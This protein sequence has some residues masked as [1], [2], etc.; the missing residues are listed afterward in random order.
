MAHPNKEIYLS[1]NNIVQSEIDESGNLVFYVM[2]EKSVQQGPTTDLI[3]NVVEQHRQCD[4]I[5]ASS[6]L[7]SD[8]QLIANP[9]AT[10]SMDA[11]GTVYQYQYTVPAPSVENYQILLEDGATNSNMEKVRVERVNSVEQFPSDNLTSTISADMLNDSTTADIILASAG[12]DIGNTSTIQVQTFPSRDCGTMISTPFTPSNVSLHNQLMQDPSNLEDAQLLNNFSAE[13]LESLQSLLDVDVDT[14]I[15]TTTEELMDSAFETRH[16]SISHQG[17][18]NSHQTNLERHVNQRLTNEGASFSESHGD[19]RRS[20][21]VL[22]KTRNQGYKKALSFESIAEQEMRESISAKQRFSRGTQQEIIGDEKFMKEEDVNVVKKSV[23]SF[24]PNFSS[25]PSTCKCKHK[26]KGTDIPVEQIWLHKNQMYYLPQI[27]ILVISYEEFVGFL[28]KDKWYVSVGEITHRLI[29][30]FRNEVESYL[31]KNVCDKQFLSLEEIEYLKQ[32]K[33]VNHGMKSGIMISLDTLREM[34]KFLA[35]TKAFIQAPTTGLSNAAHGNIYRKLLEKN[36]RCSKCGGAVW[37]VNTIDRYVLVD[38]LE[39]HHHTKIQD[40]AS[41]QISPQKS[42]YI[43]EVTIGKIFF[44]SFKLDE[45]I[46]ISL[47]EIVECQVFNLQILQSRLVQLQYRPRPAPTAVDSYFLKVNSEVNQT[48]WI[49]LMTLRCV[50]CMSRLRSP[51]SQVELLL[52]MFSRGQ[53][54]CSF[55]TEITA[56]DDYDSVNNETVYTLD[57]HSYKITTKHN[58]TSSVNASASRK[59]QCSSSTEEEKGQDTTRVD[60]NSDLPLKPKMKA[61]KVTAVRCSPQKLESLSLKPGVYYFSDKNSIVEFLKDGSGE[62]TVLEELESQITDQKISTKSKSIKFQVKPAPNK[63]PHL[64]RNEVKTY[65]RKKEENKKTHA[66]PKRGYKRKFKDLEVDTNITNI[67]KVRGV[68]CSEDKTRKESD[69]S[70]S[71]PFY[72][73]PLSSQ[74]DIHEKNASVYN[75]PSNHPCDHG[76]VESPEVQNKNVD[77]TAANNMEEEVEYPHNGIDRVCFESHP[78]SAKQY[79]QE[80]YMQDTGKMN[81][82][83]EDSCDFYND[84]DFEEIEEESTYLNTDDKANNNLPSGRTIVSKNHISSPVPSD[85]SK[86]KHQNLSASTPRS[87]RKGMQRAIT[88]IKTF[89]HSSDSEPLSSVPN[90]HLTERTS[91]YEHPFS[92]G[93]SIEDQQRL[94]IQVASYSGNTSLSPLKSDIEM[95]SE[96]IAKTEI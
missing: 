62:R 85:I 77:S 89:L 65:S 76:Q 72:A 50:C 21:R 93:H 6:V 83:Q 91:N 14:T 55:D 1:E 33:C 18:I 74:H 66:A 37:D 3:Y 84:N 27:N 36:T 86:V 4:E 5:G 79:S 19:V 59:V 51:P 47:K 81:D 80:S 32:R 73:P 82:V 88:P 20:K 95:T 63:V 22:A 25:Y 40:P 54:T 44:Q 69:V 53:Y 92:Q 68:P 24:R 67:K 31:V 70:S 57:P 29:P 61:R 52:Q 8:P 30:N 39:I 75:I 2:P 49:D 60:L 58:Y 23:S 41:Q 15:T 90:V 17:N 71:V 45:L 11:K 35:S 10:M 13:A 96:E 34:C 64:L 9:S 94:Q 28:R 12:P 16:T 78:G 38:S 7:D 43:G 48:L 26:S 56:V 42:M 46:Y 87:S